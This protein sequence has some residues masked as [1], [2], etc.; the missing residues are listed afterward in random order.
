MSRRNGPGS[1]VLALL[2]GRT[3]Q[4]PDFGRDGNDPRNL[5]LR[6]NTGAV[7]RPSSAA[8]AL[9]RLPT[10]CN[11]CSATVPGSGRPKGRE[12]SSSI[13]EFELDCSGCRRS[14]KSELPGVAIASASCWTC[15]ASLSHV[16]T[17]S[18]LFAIFAVLFPIS[19]TEFS[20]WPGTKL[21]RWKTHTV[22]F[23]QPVEFPFSTNNFKI[24]Q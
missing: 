1:D 21:N 19:H 13:V 4:L 23:S 8:R 14:P 15:S 16:F 11:C 18:L 22:N 20:S 12:T 5:L 2:P 7:I 3:E 24:N 17:V 9:P 10:D 6:V